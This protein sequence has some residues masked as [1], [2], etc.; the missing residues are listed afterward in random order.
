MIG[1]I[2]RCANVGGQVAKLAGAIHALADS[3]ASAHG[4]LK[5]F[6]VCGNGQTFQHRFAFLVFLRGHVAVSGGLRFL[7]EPRREPVDVDVVHSKVRQHE[8]GVRHVPS[9]HRLQR[10]GKE[11]GGFL[12]AT[13]VPLA[14]ADQQHASRHATCGAV[15]Q[16][17]VVI[18]LPNVVVAGQNG[19][20][21]TVQRS[22]QGLCVVAETTV[23]P[24]RQ[25][26]AVGDDFGNG[27]GSGFVS[28]VWLQS[29]WP[30]AT[31]RLADEFSDSG[32]QGGGRPSSSVAAPHRGRRFSR[33]AATPSAK[34]GSAIMSSARASERST[35]SAGLAVR[36]R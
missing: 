11:L 14:S 19:A 32:S 35:E 13:L 22:V 2:R 9:Q 21:R 34:S 24:N 30:I 15:Q 36:S 5:I 23:L 1:Q 7:G 18:A 12:G 29:D 17:P 3:L 8:M 31:T 28:H 26:D 10:F 4:G 25:D 33:S 6:R 20:Q 27:L 16:V